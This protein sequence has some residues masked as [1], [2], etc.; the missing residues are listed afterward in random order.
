[1]SDDGARADQVSAFREFC[2]ADELY[3]SHLSP[4]VATELRFALNLVKSKINIGMN[5]VPYQVTRWFG[6]EAADSF[7]VEVRRRGMEIYL[8][9]ST[10]R[11]FWKCSD[12]NGIKPIL[13]EIFRPVNVDLLENKVTIFPEENSVPSIQVPIGKLQPSFDPYASQRHRKG[14]KSHLAAAINKNI[15]ENPGMVWVWGII[16]L[17]LFVGSV[18]LSALKK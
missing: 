11:I 16:F 13:F 14:R 10:F 4:Q 6:Q 17:V 2:E 5:G 1:M 3:L 12:L 18:V 15:H 9:Q 8:E 7:M